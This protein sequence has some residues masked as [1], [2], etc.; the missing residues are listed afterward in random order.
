MK[1]AATAAVAATRRRSAAVACA[2][3]S[4]KGA[5]RCACAA[6]A[7]TTILMSTLLCTV[8]KLV[9]DRVGSQLVTAVCAN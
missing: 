2:A 8:T 7:M 9:P 5:I 4:K 3:K 6:G 1:C